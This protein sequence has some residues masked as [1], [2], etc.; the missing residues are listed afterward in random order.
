MQYTSYYSLP[1]YEDNDK[2]AWL[3]IFNQAMLSID[4]GIHGAKAAADSADATA[5]AAQSAASQA[6]SDVTALTYSL[7]TAIGS[8]NTITSLIGNGTPTTTDQTLIGAINEI[9]AKVGS[10]SSQTLAA[11]ATSV[12]FT[13]P[14]TGNHLIDFY[15]EG[16]A[17]YTAIDTSVAGTVTL[18]YE[19]AL[20][21]RTVSMMIKE[22]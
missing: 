13:V 7:N 17:N 8:I 12:S 3:T 1:Q 14:T 20:S 16:G 2:T 22:V 19:V 18:T 10:V 6:S 15:C 21:A 4:T 5:T 11:N 9:N